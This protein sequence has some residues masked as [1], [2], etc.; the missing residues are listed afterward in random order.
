MTNEGKIRNFIKFLG[1]A[2]ARVVVSKQVRASGGIWLSLDGTNLYLDPGPGALVHC[3]K[4]KPPLDPSRLDA[5]LLSHRHLDHSGDINAM[6]EAMTE[7]TFKKRGKLLAPTEALES[8][9]VVLKYVRKYLEKVEVLKEKGRYKVG[10]LAV[11]TPIRHIHHGSETYGFKIKSS[12][13]TISYI[14]DTK[15]FPGL[16]KAYKADI[17]ILSVLRVEPS[18]LEHLCVED[19]KKLVKGIRPR[20][21]I[22]THFGMWML[23]A[24]PW[25]VAEQLSRELRAKVIA[26]SDG[27]RFVV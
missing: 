2:G 25:E 22:M 27:M 13:G 8:D 11:S 1:T 5:I 12:R 15:Y 6:I 16:V 14:S 20:V 26:A 10:K 7:G 19:V 9:P 23:R 24:K 3:W 17:L 4:S 21:T 18:P